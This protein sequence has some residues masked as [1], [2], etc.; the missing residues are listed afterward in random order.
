[1][2]DMDMMAAMGIA[3]FGK[4]QKQ[5]R[6]DPKRFDK[7]K[8]AEVRHLHRFLA[9]RAA[10]RSAHRT[11]LHRRRPKELRTTTLLGRAGRI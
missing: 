7:S 8:R 10:Y 4:Q 6:L 9:R 3:G 11:R 5:R 2:D 1:M